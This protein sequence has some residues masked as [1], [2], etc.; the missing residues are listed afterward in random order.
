MDQKVIQRISSL[1][2]FLELHH[3]SLVIDACVHATDT[4]HLHETF[5]ERYLSTGNYYHGRPVSA[6]DL[7]K[8][9][10]LASINMC[11][12][13]PDQG[14]ICITDDVQGN[15]DSFLTANRYVYE[16]ALKHP[17]KFIPAGL[18]DA[19]LLG[20]DNMLKLAKSFVNDFGYLVMR[21]ELAERLVSGGLEPVWHILDWII[22]MGAVPVLS[23]GA[24]TCFNNPE[25]LK[26]L[27]DRYQKHPLMLL[28]TG[29]W[30]SGWQDAEE[31]YICVRQLGL[32]F[33]DLKFILCMRRESH[34]EADLVAFQYA[35]ESFTENLFC[36]SGAPYGRM[37][38]NFGGFRW[39]L[40]SL[41]DAE[42]HTDE[43]IRHTPG[44]FN[45]QVMRNYLGGNLSRL[46]LSGYKNL[47]NRYMILP[48][49]RERGESFHFSMISSRV[50]DA[51]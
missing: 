50:S 42:H 33:A 19:D 16:S 21:I 41:M 15:F 9:M 7:L 5:R 31:Y 44:L 34:T 28:F 3:D 22:E 1:I 4:V 10:E 39:M 51:D 29:G 13:S 36:A 38:W 45:E 14:S 46:L 37:T 27:A 35:G 32:Q 40:L 6:E 11:L 18:L 26:N 48:E 49:S 43:R 30:H 23:Y 17:E 20:L 25:H 8:E 12:V 2:D 47:L 24:G